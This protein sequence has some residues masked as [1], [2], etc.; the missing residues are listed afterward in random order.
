MSRAASHPRFP[1]PPA[2][3]GD[4]G[5]CDLGPC[6]VAAHVRHV[7]VRP[8]LDPVQHAQRRRAQC[9]ALRRGEGLGGLD[10]CAGD[11]QP[12]GRTLATQGQNLAVFGNIAGTGAAVLPSLNV[13]NITVS[14]D[15]VND[16]ITVLA[17]YPYQP[18]FGA[19]IPTF[20]GGGGISTAFTLNISVTMRAL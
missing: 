19:V 7:R 20:M 12:P 5:V 4:G 9:G 2:R 8:F 1:S 17:A 3:T 6:A 15:T 13:G 14:E 10:Q 18:L 16:N 11:G